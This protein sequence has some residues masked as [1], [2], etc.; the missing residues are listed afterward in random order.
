VLVMN[1]G[2]YI[3]EGSFADLRKSNNKIVEAY[4]KDIS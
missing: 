2:E 1:D 3:A 4:F